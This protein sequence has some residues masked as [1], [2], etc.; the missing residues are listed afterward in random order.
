VKANSV[1]S[2]KSILRKFVKEELLLKEQTKSELE[3][4]SSSLED[5]VQNPDQ[6]SKIRAAV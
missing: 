1:T 4:I 2:S 3:R 5:I 6:K